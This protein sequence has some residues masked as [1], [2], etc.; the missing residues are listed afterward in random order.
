MYLQTVSK[1]LGEQNI[2]VRLQ[3]IISSPDLDMEEAEAIDRTLTKSCEL[4][5]DACR[6]RRRAYWSVELHEVK[7]ALSIWC[8]LKSWR[9]RKLDADCLLERT[10]EI[11][12]HIEDDFPDKV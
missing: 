7:C 2:F 9:R 12:I 3:R 4:G 11:G 10:K 5:D 1:Y 8:I 6:K